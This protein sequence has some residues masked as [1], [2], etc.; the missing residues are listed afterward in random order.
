MFQNV[1]KDDRIVA[2]FAQIEWSFDVDQE[3][4]GIRI[5]PEDLRIDLHVEPIPAL[6]RGGKR[7]LAVADP[8][9]SHEASCCPR[10]MPTS[11]TRSG[12]FDRARN[13]VKTRRPNQYRK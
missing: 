7:E 13:S 8:A 12:R 4:I 2:A 10:S 3:M 5:A 11:S 9:A 6:D 1:Q